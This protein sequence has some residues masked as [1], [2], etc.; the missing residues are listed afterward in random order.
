[1]F[2]CYFSANAVVARPRGGARAVNE[3]PPAALRAIE[4]VLRPQFGSINGKLCDLS[5]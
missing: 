3:L 1:M 4:K 5:K 2:Q